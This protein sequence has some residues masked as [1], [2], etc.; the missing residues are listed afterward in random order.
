MNTMT[1]TLTRLFSETRARLASGTLGPQ[2]L[3]R[4]EQAALALAA[5][6][7]LRQRLLYIHAAQPSI[8]APIIN[9]TLYEPVRG[10]L[11]QIDPTAP[12]LPYQSVRDALLEGWR[13]VHFP[14]NRAPFDDREVDMLGYEFILEKMEPAH[15]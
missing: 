12:E 2:D 13:I 15:D 8:Q 7:I 4:L 6:P 3:D 11:T 9:V 14:D 10:A 5:P 1:Q